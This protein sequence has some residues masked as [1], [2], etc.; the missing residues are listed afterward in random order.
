LNSLV[1][2]I[3]FVFVLEY[4]ERKNHLIRNEND[5]LTTKSDFALKTRLNCAAPCGNSLPSETSANA[6]ETPPKAAADAEDSNKM[7]LARN[8]RRSLKMELSE[9]SAEANN[10][11]SG[12]LVTFPHAEK[13]KA[14][15]RLANVRR[16][17]NATIIFMAA[18]SLGFSA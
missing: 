13:A 17:A 11:A 16:L 9:E 10:A 4:V 14:W 3:F 6:G 8:C 7:L 2:W 18:R 1:E 12:L 5:A 15:L